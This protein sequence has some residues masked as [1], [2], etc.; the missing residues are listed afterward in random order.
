M[1]LARAFK[2][3]CL[4]F[5]RRRQRG[6]ILLQ[7][8]P[9]ATHLPLFQYYLRALGCGF[10]STRCIAYF[11]SYGRKLLR[12]AKKTTHLWLNLPSA[13][14]VTRKALNVR[15]GKGKGA[16]LG[17]NARIRS[18]AF[19][20]ASAGVRGGLWR[21]LVRFVRARCPF[22]LH[23]GCANT[24]AINLGSRWRYTVPA[25]SWQPPRALHLHVRRYATVQIAELYAVLRRLNRIKMLVYFLRLFCHNSPRRSLASQ[26]LLLSG[27]TGLQHVWRL[28]TTSAGVVTFLQRGGWGLHSRADGVV[29]FSYVV[30]PLPPPPNFTVN[31]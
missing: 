22:R 26:S 21:K 14:L 19:V 1:F 25:G 28:R 27:L 4:G 18:G 24:V 29:V 30:D 31:A 13:H 16:R 11:F 12:L 6:A 17:I 15:M 10:L 5:K 8:P 3:P 9:Q 2:R 23:A 20:V 7:R